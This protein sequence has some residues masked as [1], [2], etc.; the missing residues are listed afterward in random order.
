MNLTLGS[1][2]HSECQCPHL[3]IRHNALFRWI[4][5][6]KPYLLCW[7]W[8]LGECSSQQ[9]VVCLRQQPCSEMVGT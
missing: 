5:I 2:A 8:G 6:L 3:D 1:A 7:K 4:F 9:W